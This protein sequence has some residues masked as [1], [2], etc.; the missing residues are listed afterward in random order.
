MNLKSLTLRGFKSFADK[1]TLMFEPG[2]SVVIGPNGSGKSNLVDAVLWV[3]G[4]QSPSSLRA[5]LMED[6]I[7]SG[8]SK[9]PALG[10][11]EVSLVL[12][13]SDGFL[14]LEFSEVSI[15]RRL[16]R[17]GESQYFL[18]GS[19]CRLLDIQEL[20]SDANLGQKLH[21]VVSQG[22]LDQ[23][24]TARLEERRMLIEE[25]AGV[26]KHRRRQERVSKKLEMLSHH[27]E[28]IKE[29]IAQFDQ[30]IRPLK[31]QASRAKKF[32]NLRA[33]LRE[34]SLNL[35]A[36]ELSRSKEAWERLELEEEKLEAE[37][38]KIQEI[39]AQVEEELSRCQTELSKKG[40]SAT[41]MGEFKE[42]FHGI[43]EKISGN[44]RVLEEK[45]HNL[46]EKASTLRQEI[47]QAEKK[48]REKEERLSD[49]REE[50]TA[51]DA[52]LADAHLELKEL[53]R[54][55]E[56]AKKSKIEWDEK[57][58]K[59]QKELELVQK[60]IEELQSE[61]S[62][63]V[64]LAAK[65]ES[66]LK[67]FREQEEKLREQKKA[68]SREIRKAKESLKEAGESKQAVEQAC[69]SLAKEIVL[70]QEEL[71][72]VRDEKE[73]AEER[74]KELQAAQQL[75]RQVFYFPDKL[76]VLKSH[77]RVREI[78]EVKGGYE[79]A[80]DGYLRDLLHAYLVDKKTKA[81]KILDE[82]AQ[83]HSAKLIVTEALKKTD[84][85]GPDLPTLR[86]AVVLTN[87]EARPLERLF[88]QAYVVDSPRQALEL[89]LKFP[90]FTFV[91]L[92]GWVARNGLVAS[93]LEK[94]FLEMEKE[95]TELNQ[96]LKEVQVEIEKFSGEEERLLSWL[97]QL[98]EKEKTQKENLNELEAARLIQQRQFEHLL[99]EEKEIL[100]QQKAADKEVGSI[101]GNL[102]EAAKRFG[103]IKEKLIKLKKKSSDFN[104][105]LSEVV[106]QQVKE[107]S[108]EE[109]LSQ[110]VS[111]AQIRISSLTEKGALIKREIILL[112]KETQESREW[113]ETSKSS[114]K[115]LE[116]L[117]KR[118]DPLNQIYLK[119]LQQ[120]QSRID[121]LDK[122]RVSQRGAFASLGEQVEK[123]Q[124][125][126]RQ[127]QKALL[128]KQQAFNGVKEEK[129]KVKERVTLL[130]RQAA[131]EFKVSI[132]KLLQDYPN[133]SFTKAEIEARLGDIK[134]ELERL[135]TVNALAV[136]EWEAFQAKR[137]A[138]HEQLQD[139]LTIN[140][141]IFKIMKDVDKKLQARFL[142]AFESVNQNFKDIFK[143]LFPGGEASL[144]LVG[145]NPLESGVEIV[146]E[147]HGKKLR[148]LSLL[149]GGERS[150]VALSLLLAFHRA[151]PS[152]LYVFDEVEPALD[153]ANLGRFIK[154][155]LKMREEAQVII[156]THQRLTMEVGDVLYGVSIGDDGVSKVY[157]QRVPQR[158]NQLE[159]A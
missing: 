57:V 19:L 78:I 126:S 62:E 31:K 154:L 45:G 112:K 63:Q 93:P 138:L 59:M 101:E 124:A 145:D 13:N 125:K 6:V 15:T 159:M 32:E 81:V 143:T 38:K 142:T 130:G 26:L 114:V 53:R 128:E 69:L 122:F 56:Q 50:K 82:L 49:Y 44:L 151:S 8:S 118:L 5:S 54:R 20:L 14:P 36:F 34:L 149:S 119:L 29:R 88:E 110:E 21:T 120:A 139:I 84:G 43:Y 141:V 89:S 157:S 92:N 74:R 30:Q 123:L 72:V 129:G 137:D 79:K 104:V 152:P 1:T 4:E 135:G 136:G 86:K 146:A 90:A 95:L 67:L 17:S 134:K 131:Q 73:K 61:K 68:V 158:M 148:R 28:K 10:L 100:N 66:S 91:T 51:Q 133:F 117:I 103:E 150:L 153:S 48:L 27:I 155:L 80:V 42:K 22:D 111:Q 11:A 87:D 108:L 2:I 40:L 121:W 99:E 71:R 46:V 18:N 70:T 76:G 127:L 33:E 64:E 9:R 37:L 140:K 156:I 85:K 132:E 83:L 113:L 105:A 75:F 77:Q 25:V 96:Q 52:L 97:S 12:D 147:P 47:Y 98:K 60:E 107:Q 7:F 24:I 106:E 23:I 65:A 58:K 41:D 39:L 55:S 102:R 94:G 35:L 3:F 115:S 116:L 109:R 144:I 16:Y